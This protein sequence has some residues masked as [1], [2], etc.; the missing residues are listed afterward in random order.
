MRAPDST[1][2]LKSGS[3]NFLHGTKD[4]LISKSKQ[5]TEATSK[6]LK[7]ITEITL[8]RRQY[9]RKSHCSNLFVEALL[10]NTLRN[11]QSELALKREEKKLRLQKF[12]SENLVNSTKSENVNVNWEKPLPG[13][14]TFTRTARSELN[15]EVQSCL[16]SLD[17]F[18][19]E[20]DSCKSKGQ[21]QPSS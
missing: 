6:L 17:S 5:S 20:L 3:E 10:S 19:N 1:A 13:G 7:W 14:E 16:A 12:Y 11:A 18:F 9:R 15:E 2:V 8:K 21:D 4:K